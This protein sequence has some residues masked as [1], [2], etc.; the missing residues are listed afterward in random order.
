MKPLTKLER[1]AAYL[2]VALYVAIMA[3]SFLFGT[4]SCMQD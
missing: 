3:F 2:I 1:F 4:F